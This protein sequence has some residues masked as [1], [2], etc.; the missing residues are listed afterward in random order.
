MMSCCRAKSAGLDGISRSRS[1]NR[2]YGT[3]LVGQRRPDMT[4]GYVGNCETSRSKINSYADSGQIGIVHQ[5]I[6]RRDIPL[7]QRLELLKLFVN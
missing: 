5:C 6:E 2:S 7:N 3:V 4:C 1:G